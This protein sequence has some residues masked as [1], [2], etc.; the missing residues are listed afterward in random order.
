M[1]ELHL[2]ERL[3]LE[4]E[5]EPRLYLRLGVAVTLPA[6]TTSAKRVR[7]VTRE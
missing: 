2:A 6:R 4:V 3:A 1:L 7:L 5:L